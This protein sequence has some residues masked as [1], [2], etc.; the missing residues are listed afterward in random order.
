M[1]YAAR[2]RNPRSGRMITVGGSLYRRL[3][4]AGD[5]DP[6]PADEI[7]SDRLRM[8]RQGK[9]VATTPQLADFT[10]ESDV[11][12]LRARLNDELGHDQMAVRGQGAYAGSMVARRVPP[13]K[14][15][16][17]PSR[18]STR[19]EAER[20]LADVFDREFGASPGEPSFTY[21]YES[22]E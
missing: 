17:G 13:E 10:Q 14:R 22:V 15:Q 18:G 2:V 1:E 19:R 9:R 8:E 21:S 5:I 16:G 20:W 11:E 12:A 4:A 3:V 6:V 7:A